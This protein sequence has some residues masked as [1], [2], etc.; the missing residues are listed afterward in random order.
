MTT[1]HA[2][3]GDNTP[4]DGALL[5]YERISAALG[6]F[7]PPKP[8][9]I[10]AAFDALFLEPQ[11]HTG[12]MLGDFLGFQLQACTNPETGHAAIFNLARWAWRLREQA[13]TAQIEANDFQRA[14]REH[15]DRATGAEALVTVLR[16]HN[17]RQARNACR[18][19]RDNYAQHFPNRSRPIPGYCWACETFA[20]RRA[21]QYWAGYPGPGR[22]V[23]PF[24]FGGHKV[25]DACGCGGVLTPRGAERWQY[26]VCSN[27]CGLR[28][29]GDGAR[30]CPSC[31]AKGDPDPYP[32]AWA[33]GTDDDPQP[34]CP[35]CNAPQPGW[36]PEPIEASE[37]PT[38]PRATPAPEDVPGLHSRAMPAKPCDCGGFF[39]ITG[40]FVHAED[41]NRPRRRIDPFEDTRG[42]GGDPTEGPYP[43]A[44][45]EG[46]EEPS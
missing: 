8:A 24:D 38:P 20:F 46:G 16:T 43:P 31:A 9:E 45:A 17:E 28:I 11:R 27:D 14:S 10:L 13:E 37:P 41:C 2:P 22:E 40:A 19:C 1:I 32:A 35:R 7:R 3:I 36:K 15:L 26:L 34:W 18:A 5:V 25:G 21:F 12:G 4:S 44:A 23:D 39:E 29:R 6:G 33:G 30:H 42:D